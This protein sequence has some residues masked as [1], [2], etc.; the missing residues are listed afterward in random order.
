MTEQRK[1]NPEH[2]KEVLKLINQA[3]FLNALDF[4]VEE[5]DINYARVTTTVAT[6][7]LNPFG[8]ICGGVFAALLDVTSYWGLYAQLEEDAGFTTLDLQT[9][10]LRAV[11]DG[12]LTCE[13]RVTKSGRSICLCEAVIYDEAGHMIATATS[14]MFLSPAIQPMQAVIDNMNP[15]ITLPPKFIWGEL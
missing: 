2:I 11:K 14:K 4:V 6:K 3:P 8:Q 9:N 7:H 15:D 13:A 1:L 12:K 10:Y 5:M